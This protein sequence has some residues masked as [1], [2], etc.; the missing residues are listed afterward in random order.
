MATASDSASRAETG[1]EVDAGRSNDGA[2]RTVAVF[3]G[4]TRAAL[5]RR[6]LPDTVDVETARSVDEGRR[7]VDP[8][9][10]VALVRHELSEPKRSAIADVLADRGGGVRVVLTTSRHEP[11]SDSVVD[12]DACLCEPIDRT[13]LRRVVGRQLAMASYGRLLA[14]Y[15]E[16]TG[17]PGL[18]GGRTPRGRTG[19]RRALSSPGVAPG[20]PGRRDQD[21]PEASLGRG[22][23]VGA[24][25]HRA[26]GARADGRR[27]KTADERQIP[28]RRLSNLRTRLERH[29]RRLPG[30]VPAAGRVRLGVYRL[31]DASG[32]LGPREPAGR[33]SSVTRALRR[34]GRRVGAPRSPLSR[35][36]GPARSRARSRRDRSPR[37]RPARWPLRGPRRRRLR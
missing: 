24:V 23:A 30:R 6:W 21:A 29:P 4:S 26:A 2:G 8:T 16:C 1:R 17:W 9:T 10:T 18:Q 15:Y 27:A 7:I 25:R 11:V 13:A 31:R 33:P 34:P 20:G 37:R 22:G 36:P 19:G 14:E 35:S 28:T 3:D 32:P 12:E 5:Y